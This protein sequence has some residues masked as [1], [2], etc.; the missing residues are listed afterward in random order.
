MLDIFR[1]LFKKQKPAETIKVGVETAPLSEEQLVGVTA[2]VG[3]EI[4]PIQLVT[5]SGQSIGRQ[6]DHNE[7]ALFALSVTLADNSRE[8][9][10]GIFIIADGMGGHQHGEIASS[11]A[12]RVMAEYMINKLYSP[13]LGSG[14]EGMSDSI[15][16]IM[17]NGVREAQRA[18]VRAA[19]GGGTT[20][21]AA[22]VLGE[23]V[24]IAH[25]GDSRA[26]FVFPDGRMQAITQD[27]SLVRRLQ[28]LGQIT[29]KEALVHPQRN[30]LYRALGQNE[31]FRPDVNTHPLPKPGFMMIC[32]DGLW[33]VV[34]EQE[35]FR[36]ITTAKSPAMACHDMVEA[37]NAAGG[38]DN[39]SVVLVEYLS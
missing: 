9:P 34:P 22:L 35:L 33:G 32:S 23:Q 27:H 26:Y 30:V 20:L 38:P 2:K 6:R 7:D 16:E 39:I 19:P 3:V 13:I 8:L 5:A 18:V 10:F 25:V 29:E 36:I 1:R 14:S 11:V 28:D 4:H 15:Q 17:E 31:P 37:A 24:T 21:T 12:A